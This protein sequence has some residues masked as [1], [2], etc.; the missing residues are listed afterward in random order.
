MTAVQR[1]FDHAEPQA[2][3][4]VVTHHP[5][6]AH[7]LVLG[8]GVIGRKTMALEQFTAGGVDLMLSGHLHLY[9]NEAM[10]VR[11]GER[12]L[13]AAQAGTTISDRLLPGYP[14]SYNHITLAEDAIRITVRCWSDP[15]AA[16]RDQQLTEYHRDT[17]GWRLVPAIPSLDHNN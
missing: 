15:I 10:A 9:H 1:F 4:V 17:D 7:E 3:R 6:I 8:R 12:A 2:L 13:V 5:F 11:P 14:N 16:F